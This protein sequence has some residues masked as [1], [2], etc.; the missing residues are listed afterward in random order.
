[1]KPMR[2]TTVLTLLLLLAVAVATAGDVRSAGASGTKVKG[3]WT[4]P[5]TWFGGTL[6]AAGDNVTIT[7]GD[8]VTID[9]TAVVGDLTIGDGLD[10]TTALIF[11]SAKAVKLSVTGNL[12]VNTGST[13]RCTGGATAPIIDTLFIYRDFVN[14]G[15]ILDFRTGSGPNYGV[16]YVVFVGTENSTFT[17]KSPAGSTSNEFNG[18][19]FDKTGPARIFLGSDITLAGGSSTYPATNAYIHFKNGIVETGSH[20]L[21]HQSTSSTTYI[22]GSSA[23]HVIGWLGRGMSSSGTASR[24]YAVGDADGYRPINIRSASSGSAT[25]HYLAVSVVRGN[26]AARTPTYAGGIDKVSNVRFYKIRYQQGTGSSPPAASMKFDRFRPSYHQNDG[27]AAGNSNLRGAYSTD[28]L[29]TWTGLGQ[30]VY[31]DTTKFTDPPSYWRT[32]S[33]AAASQIN[34]NSGQS[35]WIAIARASGSTENT[36]VFTPV[37]VEETGTGIPETFALDQNYPN[38]FNPATVI[39][40]SIPREGHVTLEVFN[41][42]GQAVGLLV[43]EEMTPGSYRARFDASD[44]ASGLYL[45][46]LRWGSKTLTGKMMLVR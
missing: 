16:C 22:G 41:L 14:E 35:A 40:F 1:M 11:S 29:L 7:D 23:S 12:L 28:S 3:S 30:V 42:L 33:L 19:T 32:D 6:P 31:Q 36:L 15:K 9:T 2:V 43:D 45:Y 17:S 44:F 8:S 21:I 10:T 38:P 25:G 20:T 37:A 13:F 24:D 39:G 5:S 4:S 27:V 46:T 26:A 34:L 18:I